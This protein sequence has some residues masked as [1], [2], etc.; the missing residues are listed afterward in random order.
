MASVMVLLG[1]I[2]YSGYRL[3]DIYSHRAQEQE[4]YKQLIVYRPTPQPWQV[5]EDDITD[6]AVVQ[7]AHRPPIVNQSILDLQGTHPNV[8]GWV[9]VPGTDVDHPFVQTNDNSFYLNRDI[10]HVFSPAGTVFMDYRNCYDFSDFHTLVYGHHMR[11]G[12]MFGTLREFNDRAFFDENRVGYIF[13]P[14]ETY[15]LE[16]FAFAI[17]RNNDRVVYGR[18]F[19]TYEDREYFIDYVRRVA[20]HYNDIEVTPDDRF[21]TLSTCRNDAANSRMILVGV[22]R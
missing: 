20:L 14:F 22:L 11:N 3:W 18:H 9:S 10:N 1:V 8:V 21:I 19:D 15:V 6:L 4:L 12:S 7:M 16:I 2:G 13:L 17:I 5:I